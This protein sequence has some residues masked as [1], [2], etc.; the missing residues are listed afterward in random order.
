MTFLEIW[1]GPR[2]LDAGDKGGV[3]AGREKELRQLHEACRTYD[4]I[5]IT[6]ESGIGKTSFVEAGLRPMLAVTDAVVPKRMLWPEA[7]AG[8]GLESVAPDQAAERVYRKL[9]GADPLDD[10]LDAH[11]ALLGVI[12][13]RPAVVILD[14]YEELIRYQETLGKALLRLVARTAHEARVPHIVISRSEWVEKLRP[15]EG[16]GAAIWPLR[17]SEIIDPQALKT[18]V[19]SPA[20]DIAQFDDAATELLVHAWIAARAEA[21]RQRVQR[22]GAE[23][24][25]TVGLLH[26]HA[27][28]RLFARWADANDPPS[29]VTTAYIE[30]FFR[31]YRVEYVETRDVPAANPTYVGKEVDPRFALWLIDNALAM[32][33]RDQITH[34]LRDNLSDHSIRWR[35]GP[36]LQLAR[37]APV[38]RSAGFK[39]P[40]S[41]LSLVPIALSD[42]LPGQAFDISHQL[43]AAGDVADP[44]ARQA[45]FDSHF[46]DATEIGAGIA[47]GWRDADVV[48]EMVR[49]LHFALESVSH[50]SVNVLRR[51]VGSGQPIYE[52]VHDGMGPALLRWA[53]EFAG[54]DVAQIGTIAGQPGSLLTAGVDGGDVGTWTVRERA[55][56]GLALR[57]EDTVVVEK[58]G[59]P[60]SLIRADAFSDL[61][62]QQG[63][64]IGAKFAGTHFSNVVFEDCKL[65]STLFEN[66]VLDNVTFR[67]TDPGTSGLLNLLT[68]RFTPQAGETARRTGVTFSG[69]PTATGLFFEGVQG[70]S[71][72]FERCSVRSLVVVTA[73]SGP[74]EA[75]F[76]FSD[77]TEI[78]PLVIYGSGSVRR[79]TSDDSVVIEAPHGY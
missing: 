4:I 33:V 51:F 46:G 11:D 34:A 49:C 72:R 60:Q 61:V 74:D 5:Q 10:D 64:F 29:H 47:A 14:Q 54:S 25:P 18:I 21:E 16:S 40:Q 13:D 69:L 45:I 3:L 48:G 41:L 63:D 55:F 50:S 12:G 23:D 68:I 79:V 75:V 8:V 35:N 1:P 53:R 37:V 38:L 78:R 28:L 17:L 19:T 36:A 56:W 71:W 15:L 6:A 42:E 66:C 65:V 27:L 22:L 20:R 58:M 59:R 39:V 52:L 57:D 30:S 77:G 26:F 73:Q 2:P 24:V 43:Y 31:R 76:D 70:G 9:I 62:I 7:T 32:Y 44:L 67:V